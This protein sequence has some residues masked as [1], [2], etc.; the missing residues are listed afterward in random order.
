MRAR[1]AAQRFIRSYFDDAGFLEVDTPVR[2]QAP[3]LDLH[4]DAL[5]AHDGW[6]ITS[7]EH[8]MKRLLVA[9]LPRIYQ[10]ARASRAEE[11]GALHQP[12]FLL[13]EWYR[14]Y[15]GMAEVMADT[16]ALVVGVVE[17]LRSLAPGAQL[18]DV[19]Y[20]GTRFDLS[21]PFERVSVREAYRRFADV[22][23]V[24]ALARDDEDR[25]FE[26]MVDRVEPGLTALQRPVFLHGY[27]LSQAS[28][29][30]P[31]PLDPET[32][33]RFELYWAGVELCNGFGELNDAA[34]QR[35]RYVA[36]I[37]DRRSRQM[38]VYPLDEPFLTALEEGMPPA[39]G[40]A[41]G[42]DRLLML[43]L[44]ETSLDAV[45]P[46]PIPRPE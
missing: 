46:F 34:E 33:E 25:Y 15:A 20:Q 38:P 26:L 27:P 45:V 7:P 24:V 10:I 16:E 35:R 9:G 1:A 13:L 40:N 39:G 11:L 30:R 17:T 28:L 42:L 4:V 29:A 31:D 21:R 23:D 14:A 3:G 44:D 22:D 36:A 2:V 37:E 32:A 5:S 8:H 18:R 6:L 12:E 41:L 43:A 19:S